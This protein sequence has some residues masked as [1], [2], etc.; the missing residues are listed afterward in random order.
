[1]NAKKRAGSVLI[2]LENV[3]Y[4]YGQGP[5]ILKDVTLELGEGSFHFLTGPSGAGKSSF[6]QLLYLDKQPTRGQVTVFDRDTTSLTRDEVAWLRRR[7][8][9]IFQDFRLLD[10]LT[11]AENVAL[12]LRVAGARFSAYRDNVAEMLDWVGLGDKMAY[13][14]Q[15]LSGGEKQRVAIARA[16]VA[17]PDLILADEPT[18]S[19]DPQMAERIVRLFLEMNRLGKTVLFA[20]HDLAMVERQGLPVLELVDGHLTLEEF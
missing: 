15:Q 6:L 17:A 18:G 7:M 14:P 10:H 20:T 19:V 13:F 4:R 11:A 12:P 9:V 1:M 2:Q 5:E 3:G 8:G 16:V